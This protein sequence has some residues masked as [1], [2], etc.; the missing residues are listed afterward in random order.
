MFSILAYFGLMLME[1]P[2]GENTYKLQYIA[3]SSYGGSDDS[4]H[5][6]TNDIQ[7]ACGNGKRGDI[8]VNLLEMSN[9]KTLFGQ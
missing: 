4:T 6:H 1:L 2:K 8:V 3:R 9:R 5:S 7:C